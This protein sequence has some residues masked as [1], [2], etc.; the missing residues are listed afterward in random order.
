MDGDVLHA[1][2]GSDGDDVSFGL[3]TRDGDV[4]G[5]TAYGDSTGDGAIFKIVRSWKV[6]G[7]VR[8]ARS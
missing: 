7:E 8:R 1:F 5:A 6:S 3:V 2:D 4:Y